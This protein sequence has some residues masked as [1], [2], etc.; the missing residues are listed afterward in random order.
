MH[1]LNDLFFVIL[2]FDLDPLLKVHHSTKH[3]ATI[4]EIKV[5]PFDGDFDLGKEAEENEDDKY[6]IGKGIN[7]VKSLRQQIKRM[8]EISRYRGKDERSSFS[9]Y[10]L[11]FFFHF[12]SSRLRVHFLNKVPLVT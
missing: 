5:G 12:I 7:R 10:S 2:L 8:R 11:F 1:S 9:I 6:E 3:Y 4:Y